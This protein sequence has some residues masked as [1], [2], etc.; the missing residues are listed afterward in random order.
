M[1]SYYSVLPVTVVKVMLPIGLIVFLSARECS[2][3]FVNFRDSFGRLAR[4]RIWKAWFQKGGGGTCD[5]KKIP[6]GIAVP[7]IL[8]STFK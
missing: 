8:D 3:M 4:S 2:G 1:Y 5:F 6:W 7:P